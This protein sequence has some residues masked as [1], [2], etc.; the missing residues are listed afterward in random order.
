MQHTALWQPSCSRETLIKRSQ[1]LAKIRAFFAEREVLEVDTPALSH[2]GVTDVHLVNFSTEFIGPNYAKGTS[3]HLQTS[4]EFHMKR[5]LA[6]GSGA[7]FQLAKAFRNEEAGRHH[8]PE[9]TMLEWYRPGFDHHQLMAEL[10]ALVHTL[11]G[12][13]KAQSCTYAEA[14]KAEL[15]LCPLAASINELKALACEHGYRDIAEHEEDKDTLLN[16]L[17]SMQVEPKL[18][19]SAP[20]F[21]Y[22]FPASQA[23]LAKVSAKDSRVAERFELYYQGYELANGFNELQDAKEQAARFAE[24]NQKRNA[25]GLTQKAADPHLLA[26]LEHGLP[27]CAGVAVGVDR[28]LM[29]ALGKKHISEV[30]TFAFDRA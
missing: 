5:L 8:N 28:L 9:F 12:T 21:V 18:G 6:A 24:D 4:P 13:E 19:Q 30:Q 25:L 7:I 10:D 29:I 27:A 15:G 1:F 3:L 2:F 14:F 20:C 26:A 11:L 22:D 23:S 16:L 17:F